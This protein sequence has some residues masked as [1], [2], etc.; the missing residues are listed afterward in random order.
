MPSLLNPAV[1]IPKAAIADA[2]RLPSPE[3]PRRHA[4][5]EHAARRQWRSG[6]SGRRGCSHLMI[7]ARIWRRLALVDSE[8]VEFEDP[9]KSGFRLLDHIFAS[10]KQFAPRHEWL[11]RNKP[12]P[13]PRRLRQPYKAPRQSKALIWHFTGHLNICC[14]KTPNHHRPTAAVI[15]QDGFPVSSFTSGITKPKILIRMKT[16]QS[17][18]SIG[19]PAS[20]P[21]T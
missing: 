19:C 2:R 10:S 9:P 21:F 12:P 1:V 5:C 6:C 7:M 15:T 18:S 13:R 11:Q 14:T 3:R 17:I 20:A 16:C 8:L 4:F